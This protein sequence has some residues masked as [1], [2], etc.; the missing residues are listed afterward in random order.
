VPF[1]KVKKL[2]SGGQT[3]ADISALKAALHAGIK[4]GGTCRKDFMTEEGPNLDLKELYKLNENPCCKIIQEFQ[5][6]GAKFARNTQSI[7]LK[8]FK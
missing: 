2:I 8:D 4:T 5:K 3:G 1:V 6:I 7:P